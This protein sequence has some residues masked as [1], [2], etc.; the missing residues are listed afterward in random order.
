MYGIKPIKSAE[1]TIRTFGIFIVYRIVLVL[2]AW[3]CK[4]VDIRAGAIPLS[5]ER[6]TY[7][8]GN[9][10]QIKQY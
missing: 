4:S 2:G 3:T 6:P 5:Y 8:V 1:H 7:T 10:Q 9:S